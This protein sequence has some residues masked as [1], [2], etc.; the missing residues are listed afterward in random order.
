M[1]FSNTN[2]FQ[3]L[4]VVPALI[5]VDVFVAEESIKL[6]IP[7][8]LFPV[9]SIPVVTPSKRRPWPVAWT[10]WLNASPVMISKQTV[11]HLTEL[12]TETD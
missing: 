5:K 10:T 8:E 6:N 1:T 11:S 3:A 9:V 4:E 7:F 2:E 12:R